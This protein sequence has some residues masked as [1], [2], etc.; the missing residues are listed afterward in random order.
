M[1]LKASRPAASRVKT[2]R[3]LFFGKTVLIAA[4]A[5]LVVTILIVYLTGLSNHRTII[6]NSL[7]SLSILCVALF[8]FMTVGLYN[9]FN[10]YDDLSHK[11][12]FT[13]RGSSSWTDVNFSPDLPVELD[14]D[15]ACAG[16][17]IS[18]VVWILVTIG[19]ILFL[20]LAE[21]ILSFAWIAL[22]AVIYWVFIRALKL[23]FS[24]SRKCEG[25]LLRSF[26]YGFSYTTLYLGWVYGV[27]YVSGAI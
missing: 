19:I 7:I 21:L 14:G 11:L 2:S 20:F 9:G 6:E 12:K 5:T 8:T 23:V 13:W 27:I 4:L 1:A 18:I 25:N 15:D 22:V 17:L 26:Y 16:I 10:I 24:K 3:K